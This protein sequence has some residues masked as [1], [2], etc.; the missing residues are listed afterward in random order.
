MPSSQKTVLI[1]IFVTGH[2]FVI[3]YISVNHVTLPFSLSLTEITLLADVVQL[4]STRVFPGTG[5][6]ALSSRSIHVSISRMSCIT[7]L[8]QL[9]A[10]ICPLRTPHTD[11][12]Y[13][14]T[15]AGHLVFNQLI[16]MIGFV[17]LKL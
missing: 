16:I 13:K 2:Y 14:H 12:L 10:D 3:L 17:A 8:G 6:G 11:S 7:A 5:T 1:H 15:Y 4:T 9:S